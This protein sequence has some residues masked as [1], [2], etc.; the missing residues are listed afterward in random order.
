VIFPADRPA[1]LT[2]GWC[3]VNQQILD[4]NWA[5]MRYELIVD[6]YFIDL[7]ELTRAD[8]T[9]TD[10]ICRFYAG[11]LTGWSVG[12]HTYI[13]VQHIYQDLND[14]WDN[15]STG[16]YR[17]EFRVDVSLPTP[18]P[19]LQPTP[20]PTMPLPTPTA[21]LMSPVTAPACPR[22]EVCI[23]FPPM[24]ATLRGIIQFRGTATRPNFQYYKFEFRPE[25]D[26][27]WNF[28]GRSDWPVTNGLLMEWNTTQI[29]AGVYWLR[30]TVVDKSGN[31]WPE[32]AELRLFVI[33]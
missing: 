1:L 18:S 22:P 7:G 4:A 30:L 14:G 27:A 8:R 11:V 24:D 15:Y 17:M 9:E 10:R 16:D 21:I 33:R 13:W 31:Y 28:L 26:K 5:Q 19:V 32:F 3:A 6:G 2:L 20:S 12:S 29:P 23:S 25:N